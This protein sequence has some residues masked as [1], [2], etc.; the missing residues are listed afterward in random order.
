MNENLRTLVERAYAS[1]DRHSSLTA[2]DRELWLDLKRA[3][4]EDVVVR[5]ETLELRDPYG[6][7][8]VDPKKLFAWRER[9]HKIADVIAYYD[10]DFADPLYVFCDELDRIRSLYSSPK[11]AK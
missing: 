1:L 5:V 9:V 10:R 8:R 6:G 2:S 3:I 7:R 4:A 11:G